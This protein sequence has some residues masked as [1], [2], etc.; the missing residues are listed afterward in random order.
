[1]PTAN[2]FTQRRLLDLA[3]LDRTLESAAHRRATLPEL[4]TIA[5]TQARL[6]E[7]HGT[8]AL[9]DAEIGDL[10]RDARK[11]DREID[12]VRV[13]AERDATRLA[14]GAAAA[15]ELENLQHEIESLRRRQGVLEDEALELM[16]KRETAERVHADLDTEIAVLSADLEKAT[17]VRDAAFAGFDG[18]AAAARS[19]RTTLT[20]E[21]PADLLALYERVRGSGKIAAAEL[22]GTQCGACRIGLDNVEVASLRAA[23]VDAVLRCSECGAILIRT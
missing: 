8:R 20:A 23:P 10:D 17:A 16:E 4:A 19:A 1:M 2:P 15:K 12:A 11:L 13:R 6:T 22:R 14:S 21:L 7:R 18:D 3:A 9:A 5:S